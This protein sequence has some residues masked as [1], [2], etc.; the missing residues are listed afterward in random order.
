MNLLEALKI[1]MALLN[2]GF[3]LFSFFR[4]QV[5][6]IGSSSRMGGSI[7]RVLV[8]LRPGRSS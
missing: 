6:A 7:R 5:I 2:I 1:V 4:P 8:R 3:G